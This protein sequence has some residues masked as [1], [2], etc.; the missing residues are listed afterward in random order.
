MK[1]KVKLKRFDRAQVTGVLR[2]VVAKESK[3]H[4]A[5]RFANCSVSVLDVHPLA[6]RVGAWASLPGTNFG[7]HV[8]IYVGHTVRLADLAA[9]MKHAT[10]ILRGN[11]DE[12][13]SRGASV[14]WEQDHPGCGLLREVVKPVK[15]AKEKPKRIG[16][17]PTMLK[18]LAVRKLVAGWEQREEAARR[19]LTRAKTAKMKLRRRETGLVAALVR[20]VL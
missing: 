19:V 2:E 12:F 13:N 15:V 1:Y 18:L 11:L 20:K 6:N 9:A 16:A 4:G 17:D 3:R 10:Y 14:V 5:K 8:K 7:G